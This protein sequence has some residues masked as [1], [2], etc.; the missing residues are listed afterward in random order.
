MIPLFCLLLGIFPT[1]CG[2]KLDD[3]HGPVGAVGCVL[4]QPGEEERKK[5]YLT[6]MSGTQS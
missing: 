5:N 1:G 6:H 2:V 3:D 4:T